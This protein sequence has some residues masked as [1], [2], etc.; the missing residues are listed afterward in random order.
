M[1]RREPEWDAEQLD[2]ALAYEAFKRDIGPNGELMSEATNDAADLTNY[3]G[4]YRYVAAGPFTNYAEKAR[5]DS[6]DAWKV[7][8]GDKPNMNGMYWTV[9]K[10]E[11]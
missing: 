8:A 5:L 3:D 9:E 6:I 7:T 1:T 2:L 11:D 10:V 4:G